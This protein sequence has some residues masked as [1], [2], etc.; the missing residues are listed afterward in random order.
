MTKILSNPSDYKNKVITKDE[1]IGMYRVYRVKQL[2]KIGKYNDLFS[3]NLDRVPE[4]IYN[5][6]TFQQIADC[7]DALYDAYGAGKNEKK[8]DI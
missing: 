3:C 5:N 4:S 7:V 8:T 1:L 6:C 2:S